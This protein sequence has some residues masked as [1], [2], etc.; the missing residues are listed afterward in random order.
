[1]EEIGDAIGEQQYWQQKKSVEPDSR[2]N[3]P[4][5]SPR[6]TQGHFAVTNKDQP[7]PRE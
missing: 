5:E 3:P 2:A 6:M 4:F 1:L 7:V